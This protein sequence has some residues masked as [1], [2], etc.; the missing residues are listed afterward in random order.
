MGGIMADF[1]DDSPPVTP[2]KAEGSSMTLNLRFGGRLL[3]PPI[4]VKG[5]MDKL[6]QTD[7]DLMFLKNERIQ[8]TADLGDGRFIV[9]EEFPFPIVKKEKEKKEEKE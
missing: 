3:S 4:L 8:L 6:A 1:V 2:L 7:D 9:C 5:L